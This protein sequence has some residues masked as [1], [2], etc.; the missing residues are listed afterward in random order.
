V[1][2]V[3]Q[4]SVPVA[5]SDLRFG[6]WAVHEGGQIIGYVANSGLVREPPSDGPSARD[7]TS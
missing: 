4:P 5:V 7:S 2:R 1:I 6:W 3:L